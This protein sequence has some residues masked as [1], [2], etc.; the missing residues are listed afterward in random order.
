MPGFPPDFPPS[1]HHGCAR[2]DT[3]GTDNV[4]DV[5]LSEDLSKPP[6]FSPSSPLELNKEETQQVD[7]SWSQDG[8]LPVCG[9]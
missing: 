9:Q 3:E 8:D 6:L 2:L 7:T 5:E 1:E 4:R